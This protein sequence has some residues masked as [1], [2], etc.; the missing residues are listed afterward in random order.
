MIG[1][2][3]IIIP[4]KIEIR[5][6]HNIDELILTGVHDQIVA[7][8]RDRVAPRTIEKYYFIDLWFLKNR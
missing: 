4:N 3:I 6:F 1:S 7:L 2:T 5:S 8:P